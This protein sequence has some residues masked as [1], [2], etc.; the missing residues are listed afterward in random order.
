M[1]L[2]Q[3]AEWDPDALHRLAVGFEGYAGV[4]DDTRTSMA[5]ALSFGGTDTHESAWT[6]RARE[7]ADEPSRWVLE[8]AAIQADS[9][10]SISVCARDVETR[11]RGLHAEL[12]GLKRWAA[13]RGM[14]IGDGGE[15]ATGDGTTPDAR[16]AAQR[17]VE[18]LL[19]R[20][21][22][23]DREAAAVL[24][25]SFDTGP[26]G[27]S[28]TELHGF[29]GQRASWPGDTATS[30]VPPAGTAPADVAQ[31]WHDLSD[32]DRAA[33]LASSPDRIGNLDGIP[34][35]VRDLA[36]RTIL[37]DERARLEGVARA[38]RAELDSNIFGGMFSNADA[39]LEQTVGKLAALDAVESTLALGDRQLL[40][41][42]LSGREAMAAVAVGDVDTADHVAVYVPGTGSTVQGN[43]AGYDEQISELRTTAAGFLGGDEAAV[44]TVTWLNYQ[45]PHFGTGMVVA[46]RSPLAD[47]AA[48]VGAARLAPFLTGLD[49][50]DTNV[51]VVGHS[52]GAWTA[53]LALQQGASADSAVFLGAPWIGT[54]DVSTLGLAEGAA[55]LVEAERDIIADLGVTGSD[56]SGLAGLTHLPSGAS[57][58]VDGRPLAASTGHSAYLTPGTTSAYGVAAVVVGAVQGVR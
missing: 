7:A 58:G 10:R 43:L 23:L 49:D 54:D 55:Y 5:V 30:D 35:A 51:T 27:P 52:Y 9:L 53:G 33:L 19:T 50:A 2:R 12:A 45:A 8:L 26:D 11:L 14:T 25:R 39:G 15:I 44:A 24:A 1:D 34:G 21:D 40:A 56:P 36:N 20:A 29:G 17:K 31:W 47:D 28:G 57:V 32:E 22:E 48:L 3:L 13:D 37:D 4:L 38:L 46:E 41:L 18:D 6:G 16:D 42:D